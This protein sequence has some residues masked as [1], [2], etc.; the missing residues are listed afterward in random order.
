MMKVVLKLELRDGDE[1]A[2]QKAMTTASGLSGV[3]SV[4]MDMKDKKLTI[5]G[6]LDPVKVV[7]KLRKI[8]PTEILTVGP[9]K[10]EDNNNKKKED[11]KKDD[12]GGGGAK[13]DNDAGGAK[14]KDDKQQQSKDNQKKPAGGDQSAA[15]KVFPQPPP[16]QF[17]Y[18]Y[19]NYPPPQM[20]QQQQ[21]PY[22]M[23]YYPNHYN[24]R[25]QQPEQHDQSDTCVIS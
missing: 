6:K 5:T 22:N 18:Q 19:Q 15:V 9:V 10:Q 23:N 21:H 16:P 13:K 4:A 8:C 24:Y 11:P 14:N 12:G 17:Y 7:G 3:E 1:K 25:Q 20:I 2:K